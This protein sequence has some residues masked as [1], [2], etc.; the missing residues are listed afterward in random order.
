MAEVMECPDAK[1]LECFWLGKMALDEVEAWAE[2]LSSCLRCAAGL[3]GLTPSD[4]LID[5]LPNLAANG[6]TAWQASTAAE[7]TDLIDRLKGLSHLAG[8]QLETQ[9]LGAAPGPLESQQA[10]RAEASSGAAEE[11]FDFLA[12][13]QSPGEIGR[14]GSYRVLGVL[15]QGGMGVVFLAEDPQL[16]RKVA[17]KALLPSR[18][19]KATS[20]ERFLREARVASA[21]KHDHIVTIYQVSEERGVPFLAM[22]FLEGES[23]ED[24]LRTSG[25]QTA[26]LAAAEVVRLGRQIAEGLAAAHRQGLIHRDIK[27]GNVWLED[28]GQGMAPRVKILDFGLAHFHKESA[29]ITQD[30]AILGTPAYMAPEQAAPRMTSIRAAICSAS[31]WSCIVC[32]QVSSRSRARTPCPH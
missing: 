19:K 28:R 7:L 9:F 1:T 4:A 22:E 17:L 10:D 32:A 12:P 26:P 20:R 6:A 23:L 3:Q 15:G 8:Q 25:K 18:A 31:A 24:R 30:G 2:H 16:Q 27:P 5:T 21:L 13:P 11:T 14:L 29:T